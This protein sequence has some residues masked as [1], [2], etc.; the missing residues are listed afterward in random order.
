MELDHFLTTTHTHTLANSQTLSLGDVL[1]TR[2]VPWQRPQP[3][4]PPNHQSNTG[5]LNSR[6][7]RPKRRVEMC[8]V[9]ARTHQ[10]PAD[11]RPPLPTQP[12]PTNSRSLSVEILPFLAEPKQIKH[13]DETCLQPLPLSLSHSLYCTLLYCRHTT[14]SLSKLSFPTRDRDLYT[15]ESAFVSLFTSSLSLGRFVPHFWS[16]RPHHSLFCNDSSLLPPTTVIQSA[17]HTHAHARGDSA[18]RVFVGDPWNRCSTPAPSC[19]RLTRAALISPNQTRPNTLSFSL[20]RPRSQ[21]FRS[22]SAP[23]L[24]LHLATVPSVIHL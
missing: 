15:R 3:T 18:P 17:A 23:L 12:P 7:W 16:H 10:V 22:A 24:P 5:E 11:Q 8:Q 4:Q 21:H 6:G 19:P 20:L 2:S 1:H 9:G 14:C 13:L